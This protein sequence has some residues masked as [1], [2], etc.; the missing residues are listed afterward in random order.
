MKAV[1][2]RGGSLRVAMLEWLID[3]RRNLSRECEVSIKSRL[4]WTLA[5]LDIDITLF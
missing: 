3:S 4:N 5:F 1:S 2:D